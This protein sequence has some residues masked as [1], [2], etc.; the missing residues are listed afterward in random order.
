MH[1]ELWFGNVKRTSQLVCLDVDVRAI[2]MLFLKERFVRVWTKFIRL[3]AG[4]VVV[5][6]L[7]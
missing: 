5:S 2:L 7:R 1:I 4:S 6:R 3:R